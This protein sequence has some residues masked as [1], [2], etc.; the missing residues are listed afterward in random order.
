[1]VDVRALP[2][3]EG[4]SMTSPRS[5]CRMAVQ[6]RAVRSVLKKLPRVENAYCFSIGFDLAPMMAVSFFSQRTNVFYSSYDGY[7]LDQEH[8]QLVHSWSARA[9]A[10]LMSLLTRMP[11][12]AC[13]PRRSILR[14]RDQFIKRRLNIVAA[15][16][17]MKVLEACEGGG[18]RKTVAQSSVVEV[19]WLHSDLPEYYDLDAK[20]TSS[21]ENAWKGI[22]DHVASVIPR[23]QHAVKSHPMDAAPLPA[24]FHG[25]EELPREVPLEFFAF[26]QVRLVIGVPSQ[27]MLAFVPNPAISIISLNRLFHLP[28]QAQ[29]HQEEFLTEWL[30]VSGKIHSPASSAEFVNILSSLPK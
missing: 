10:I 30:N 1:M 21:I 14:L 20:D 3:L 27:A 9:G 12:A 19:L 28:R 2:V 17:R 22:V 11:L 26:R 13:R 25:M 6:L 16:E 7:F 18:L 15:S 5:L 29:E 8:Y 24:F 4:V 23:P